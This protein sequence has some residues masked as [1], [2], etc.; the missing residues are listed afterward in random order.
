MEQA[1][2]LTQLLL[3][4]SA[5]IGVAID[6]EKAQLFLA[7]LNHLKRWNQSFNL[8]AITNNE[9][10]IVKHFIDSMAALAA[11]NI[12]PGSHILDIGAGAGF[13]GVP[14]KIVRPDLCVTLVEPVQNKSSFLHFIVGLLRLEGIKIFHGTIELFGNTRKTETRF[15][16]ITTRALDPSVI[17]HKAQHLLNE[18]GKAIIYSGSPLDRTSLPCDWTI[19]SEYSFELPCDYGSRTISTLSP[20]GGPSSPPVPRGT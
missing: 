2:A 12:E 14:L 6:P 4:S 19:H 16:Y 10:I 15:D 20:C 11:I 17:F 13:P 18:R 1:E 3:E 9:E 8:T 5:Q 7:Y